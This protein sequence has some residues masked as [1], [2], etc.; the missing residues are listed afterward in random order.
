MSNTFRYHKNCKGK[1]HPIKITKLQ[2][3][4]VCKACNSFIEA[5]EVQWLRN[6]DIRLIA[7]VI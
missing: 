3:K 1:G 4:I 6:D 7:G 5:S 2:R